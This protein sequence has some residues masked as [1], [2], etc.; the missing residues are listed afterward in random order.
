MPK[1][2]LIGAGSVIFTHYLCNDIFDSSAARKY[3]HADAKKA[4]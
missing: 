4:P 2:T 1:I 3:Y